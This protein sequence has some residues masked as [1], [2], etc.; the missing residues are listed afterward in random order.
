MKR[1]K[2]GS[3]VGGDIGDATG[4]AAENDDDGVS[5]TFTGV[6]LRPRSIFNGA[7]PGF[8]EEPEAESFDG[9]DVSVA[10]TGGL[11]GMLYPTARG[12]TFPRHMSR[13]RIFTSSIVELLLLQSIMAKG[14]APSQALSK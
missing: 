3:C 10:A 2:P 7:N 8:C 11:I 5:E 4:L 12:A 1:E 13:A 9:G 14:L 6:D